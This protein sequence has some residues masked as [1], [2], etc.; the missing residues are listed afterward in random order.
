[1]TQLTSRIAVISFRY[2]ISTGHRMLYSGHP[3]RTVVVVFP[4]LTAN[5]GS[6]D[7]FCVSAVFCRQILHV[8][9][10]DTALSFSYAP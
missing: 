9:P 5:D 7:S 3:K 2:E 10:R 1:M 8:V 6:T 4:I